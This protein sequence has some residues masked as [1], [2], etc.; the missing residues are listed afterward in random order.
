MP[1]Q[2]GACSPPLAWPKHIH[3]NPWDLLLGLTFRLSRNQDV[4]QHMHPAKSEQS[5]NGLLTKPVAGKAAA[6]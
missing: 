4:V 2:G 3:R 5:S 6:V 1:L